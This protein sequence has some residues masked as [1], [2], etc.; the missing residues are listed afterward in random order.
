MVLKIDF[1][2]VYDIREVQKKRER[3]AHNGIP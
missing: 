2:F 3:K 1:T